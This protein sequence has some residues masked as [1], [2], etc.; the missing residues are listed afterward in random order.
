MQTARGLVEKLK[1]R[2]A[3]DFQRKL[4]AA[5]MQSIQDVSNPLRL[6]N[7]SASFRELFRHV[8]V[9]LAPDDQVIAPSWFV[10]VVTTG[11]RVTREQKVNKEILA[12][13]YPELVT[14]EK[15]K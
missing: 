11:G 12:G 7:F 3:T 4:L 14:A 6:N 1:P 9:V 10:P 15:R 2:L 13:S 5:T 8:L